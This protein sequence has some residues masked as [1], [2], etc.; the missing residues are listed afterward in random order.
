MSLDNLACYQIYCLNKVLNYHSEDIFILSKQFFWLEGL[1]PRIIWPE[2][3]SLSMGKVY[4]RKYC[5]L[6]SN[7]NHHSSV[8]LLGQPF[9]TGGNIG[10]FLNIGLL[11]LGLSGITLLTRETLSLSTLSVAALTP[12][13]I[14]M[15]QNFGLYVANLVKFFFIIFPL[16][17]IIG[18]SEKNKHIWRFINLLNLREKTK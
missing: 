10:L 8:T 17:I 2:K 11:I 16:I 18:L 9:I 7:P 12:W 5:V 6:N 1:V 15:D 13:L 14:D 3:P 4:T